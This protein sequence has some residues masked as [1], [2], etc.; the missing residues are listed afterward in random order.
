MYNE[1]TFTFSQEIPSRTTILNKVEE[2][3]GLN[4]MTLSSLE[5]QF[6][7][8]SHPDFTARRFHLYTEIDGLHIAWMWPEKWY[9][10]DVTAAAIISL[11]GRYNECELKPAFSKWAEAMDNYPVVRP[12]PPSE[13][14]LP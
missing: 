4:E 8:I 1:A 12:G 7:T 2:I 10:L 14:R 6:W 5:D 13:D 3:S 9:L 11:G